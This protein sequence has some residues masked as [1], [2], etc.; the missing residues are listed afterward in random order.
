MSELLAHL[1]FQPTPASDW[2]IE[3]LRRGDSVAVT[4]L[5]ESLSEKSRRQR[6]LNAMP[7]LSDQMLAFLIDVDG[8]R[9]IAVAA[10]VRGRC[11]G[12]ARAVVSRFTSLT[13]LPSRSASP[14]IARS[15]L[16]HAR[17]T[18]SFTLSH[19]LRAP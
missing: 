14:G 6:F 4:E 1:P 2:V 8:E 12:I 7:R 11:V 9:H 5:F 17:R 13:H 16:C 3:P 18:E 19:V 10:R 15:T